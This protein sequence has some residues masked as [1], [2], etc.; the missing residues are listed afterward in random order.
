MKES[1]RQLVM[2]V[3]VPFMLVSL[4]SLAFEHFEVP[5]IIGIP[6]GVTVGFIVFSLMLKRHERNKG[7][8][9]A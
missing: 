1:E 7:R 3:I 8:Y 4:L 2:A 9:D 5:D 6:A